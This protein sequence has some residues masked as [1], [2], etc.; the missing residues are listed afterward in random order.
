MN[1]IDSVSHIA[2]FQEVSVV[3][4]KLMDTYIASPAGNHACS[5]PDLVLK[6]CSMVGSKMILPPYHN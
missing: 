2:I 4:N 5:L 6:L 3:K 1:Q